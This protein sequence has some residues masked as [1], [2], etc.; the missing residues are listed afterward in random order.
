M[1][2]VHVNDS[3]SFFSLNASS[4]V[5]LILFTIPLLLFIIDSPDEMSSN[6]MVEYQ[7]HSVGPVLNGQADV[8]PSLLLF[9][10]MHY[11]GRSH[12]VLREIKIDQLL[13]V[14]L[15]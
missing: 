2:S 13:Q 15:G 14:H 7:D 9:G 1:F 12:N 4:D 6:F 10:I 11:A 5:I 3:K 8:H